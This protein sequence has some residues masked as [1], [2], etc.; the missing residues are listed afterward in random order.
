M[1]GRVNIPPPKNTPHVKLILLE[2]FKGEGIIK[3]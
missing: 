2:N 1:G 3:G